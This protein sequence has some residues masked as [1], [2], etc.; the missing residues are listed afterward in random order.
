LEVDFT[1]P[2]RLETVTQAQLGKIIS[3][4]TG[5]ARDYLREEGISLQTKLIELGE[6]KDGTE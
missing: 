1:L 2:D 3:S 5:R 6:K 4:V